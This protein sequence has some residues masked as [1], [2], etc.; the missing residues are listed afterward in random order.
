MKYSN[1]N[2]SKEGE[3]RESRTIS[4][5]FCREYIGSLDSTIVTNS[6]GFFTFNDSYSTFNAFLL[7]KNLNPIGL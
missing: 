2:S 7:L 3:A 4:L 6:S 1:P 5:A